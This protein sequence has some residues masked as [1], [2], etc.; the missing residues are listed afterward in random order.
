MD[1]NGR[2]A[3]AFSRGLVRAEK[4]LDIIVRRA[5]SRS[6]HSTSVILANGEDPPFLPV[7]RMGPRPRSSQGQALRKG[8]ESLDGSASESIP[9]TSTS[10]ILAD[11]RI[12]LFLSCFGRAIRL[13]KGDES[14]NGR[15]S[16]MI[17]DSSAHLQG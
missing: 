13:C 8:D 14:L 6:G 7:V 1:S 9:A 17:P 5:V 3:Y 12:H 11:A 16:K 10:V 15:A 2:D 4:F